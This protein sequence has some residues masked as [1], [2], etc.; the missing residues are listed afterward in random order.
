MYHKFMV[1]LSFPMTYICNFNISVNCTYFSKRSDVGLL[2]SETES[3][4]TV[5]SV[6]CEWTASSNIHDVMH[7]M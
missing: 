1:I 6:L 4:R 3:D 2:Y 7:K 5:I